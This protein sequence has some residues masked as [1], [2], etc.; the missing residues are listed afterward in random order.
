M[1]SRICRTLGATLVFASMLAGMGVI[2][3]ALPSSA[4][5]AK[6]SS[7]VQLGAF[8]PDLP[9][10]RTD[11]PALEKALGGKLRIASAF[12]DWSY[13]MGGAN[14]VWMSDGGTR[15][16]LLAW[17]SSGI[18]F[19][20]VTSGAQ[21]AYLAKV[22]NSMKSFPYDV[23]VRPWPEMNASWSTWQPTADGKKP[24]GGTPTEFV[25]AWRYLVNFM[26]SRGTTHLKFVFNPDAS[27]WTTNTRISSIWPGSDYVDVLGIDGYNWGTSTDGERWQ[28]FS[29]IFTPM[30]TTLTA[31]DAN[32]PVWITEFGCKEPQQ[33]DSGSYPQPSSPVDPSH[34]KSSWL[35]D[36]MALT[37]FD[38]IQ[39]LAYFN[40]KKERNWPLTSSADSQASATRWL[41]Q[42]TTSPAAEASPSPDPSLSSATT[43]GPSTPT[44]TSATPTTSTS[45]AASPASAPNASPPSSRSSSPTPTT[46]ATKKRW[47][48]VRTSVV[49]PK[50]AGASPPVLGHGAGFMP[51]TGA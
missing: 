29:E 31:L 38:R 20:D 1:A 45:S 21:D 22:A 39:A 14:E 49:R 19:T 15:K 34:S 51:L 35:N 3:T 48:F 33:E 25:Q 6:L 13:V 5:G 37:Q 11:L 2:G 17:E 28:S 24:D 32:A 18:R 26:R 16:V 47:K 10:G 44:A 36:M 7:H 23:Y 12:V 41:S 43:N 42:L 8:V 9:Y 30:Y 27:D 40:K 4:A 46:T 50:G